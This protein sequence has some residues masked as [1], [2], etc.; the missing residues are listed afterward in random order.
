MLEAELVRDIVPTAGAAS[1]SGKRV[2]GE[3]HSLVRGMH[4]LVVRLGEGALWMD[5][6][7]YEK[8]RDKRRSSA[9]IESLLGYPALCHDAL[10]AHGDGEHYSTF[11]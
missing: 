11:R 1:A 7:G 8:R 9:P 4:V 3:K 10:E 5:V 2:G 6:Y